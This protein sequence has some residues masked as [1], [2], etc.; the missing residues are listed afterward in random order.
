MKLALQTHAIVEIT[1]ML[2]LCAAL[3]VID[4]R[5]VN[6]KIRELRHV[7]PQ[8]PQWL[9]SAEELQPEL[10]MVYRWVAPSPARSATMWRRVCAAQAGLLD[11]LLSPLSLSPRLQQLSEV[12]L[13]RYCLWGPCSMLLV[14][15]PHA[16]KGNY[17]SVLCQGLAV[18]APITP[19]ITSV[20]LPAAKRCRCGGASCRA[21]RKLVLTTP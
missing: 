15:A 9:P 13:H 2:S 1:P 8:G 17:V 12:G 10:V 14:W 21:C 16:I 6:P 19:L 7:A 4:E 20:L 18:A 3:Q 11:C 5:S